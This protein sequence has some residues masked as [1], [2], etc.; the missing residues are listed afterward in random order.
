MGTIETARDRTTLRPE[1]KEKTTQKVHSLGRFHLFLRISC[2]TL[3]PCTLSHPIGLVHAS[4]SSLHYAWLTCLW[5]PALPAARD[6]IPT[7]L[8]H[9]CQSVQ[10]G[11]LLCTLL[12]VLAPLWGG[13]L[14]WTPFVAPLDEDAAGTKLRVPTVPT[15]SGSWIGCFI[16][17]VVVDVGFLCFVRD[18]LRKIQPWA[19]D[20]DPDQ[21]F[22]VYWFICFFNIFLLISAKNKSIKYWF[23]NQYFEARKSTSKATKNQQK[24][25]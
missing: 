24:N 7:L 2:L 12:G 13:V 18:C 14:P 25:Q 10:I 8:A 21:Y 6:P 4:L 16:A 17:W 3:G 19:S 15:K 11:V 5:S 9:L 20:I 23:S 22:F 1:E